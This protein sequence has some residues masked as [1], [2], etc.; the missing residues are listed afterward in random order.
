MLPR[1]LRRR[2]SGRSLG[3]MGMTPSRFIQYRILVAQVTIKVFYRNNE[4]ENRKERAKR[5][6]HCLWNDSLYPQIGGQSAITEHSRI[7][8]CN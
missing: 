6:G 8:D 2:S 4:E 1:K 5:H 3:V 7:K